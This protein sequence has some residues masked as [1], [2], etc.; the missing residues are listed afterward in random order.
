MQCQAPAVDRFPMA[1][2]RATHRRG[3]LLP[4]SLPNGWAP[5][6]QAEARAVIERRVAP[7]G[8]HEALLGQGLGLSLGLGLRLHSAVPVSIEGVPPVRDSF[9]R[10]RTGDPMMLGKTAPE[11]R[12][13]IPTRW[14]PVASTTRRRSPG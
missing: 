6:H 1:L 4:Q 11:R 10:R 7:A 8:E 14:S 9:Y 5:R 3:K 13:V 2:S 12:S